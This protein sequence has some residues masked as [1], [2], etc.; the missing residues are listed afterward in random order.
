VQASFIPAFFEPPQWSQ[1]VSDGRAPAV[2]ILNPASGPGTAPDPGLQGAVRQAD[3]AGSRVIG[4]V[5]TNYGQLPAAR[6][7][8]DIRDYAA[9]YHVRGIFLDQTPT[10]GR[11]QLPYYQD[12]GRY[13]RQRI[14]GADI[15]INPGSF[16]DRSYMS[17]A[18]VVMVFEGTYGQYQ[19][20]TLPAW[21]RDYP[22]ARFAHTIYATPE[23][24]LPGAVH[25]SR[26][27]NAGFL[28]LTA[29]TGPNPYGSLP[30]YWPD[31]RAAVASAAC[32]G[33]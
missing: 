20:L 23:G 26:Q 25:L 2:M 32:A 31:E 28:F 11:A 12:L 17:V 9:W 29:Q 21:D 24:D 33:R 6:A 27:R 14:A 4:Y 30:G 7:R 1:A 15:W 18:D 19:R 10:E 5:G 3:R 13:I 16:P 22:A 8:A